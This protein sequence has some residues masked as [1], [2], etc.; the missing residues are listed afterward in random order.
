[1]FTRMFLHIHGLECFKEMVNCII[2]RM[3]WVGLD[4]AN[5]RLL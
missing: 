1:L 4:A 5:I 3:N 2:S